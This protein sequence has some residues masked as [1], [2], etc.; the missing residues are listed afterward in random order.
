[1]ATVPQSRKVVKVVA[2]LPRQRERVLLEEPLTLA[3]L[4]LLQPVSPLSRMMLDGA[5]LPYRPKAIAVY[6]DGKLLWKQL[7]QRFGATDRVSSTAKAALQTICFTDAYGTEYDDERLA[8]NRLA[9]EL[10]HTDPDQ[11]HWPEDTAA[12]LIDDAAWLRPS[13]RPHPDQAPLPE[14]DHSPYPCPVANP[15]KAPG[16]KPPE[17]DN[18]WTA[19]Y[20]TR[21]RDEWLRALENSAVS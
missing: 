13:G 8:D 19:E 15:S 6:V 14:A 20:A 10:L 3:T 12:D 9:W 5:G 4:A 11:A 1:M 21:E 18:E 7:A 16:H 17:W 2:L